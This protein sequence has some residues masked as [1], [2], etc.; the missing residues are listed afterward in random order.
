MEQLFKPG[1]DAIFRLVLFIVIF[2][3]AAALAVA[4]ALSGSAF[5]TGTT[6]AARQPV[7][8]SH[9]HHAGELGIDCRYCHTTVETEATAGLPPTYT[10]MTCHSQIWTGSPMLAPV[11]D[12]LARN[13]PLHWTRLN[14]LP[15]Y[16]YFDHAIHIAKGI[17]CSSCH[18]QVQEMQ[19]T[20]AV[21]SFTMGFCLD[22]HRAPQNNIRPQDEIFD[23]AWTPPADQAER[24]RALLAHYHIRPPAELTD[25]SICHR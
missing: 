11:R 6:I 9:K 2:S 13:Q 15:D 8:F 18:G 19:L 14:R 7:P 21:Q 25:C 16:V 3:A 23:M 1:A 20:Y 22:C 12:S 10:C 17:G 5:V 24:G 4:A